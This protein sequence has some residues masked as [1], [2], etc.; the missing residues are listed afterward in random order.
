MLIVLDTNV[1]M[2]GIFF[3]GKPGKILDHWHAGDINLAVSEEIAEE[4]LATAE[5]LSQRYPGTGTD[6]IL[7]LV[8][9]QSFWVVP[10]PLEV[11]LCDDPDDDK[12]IACAL[13]ADAECVI[14]GDKALLRCDGQ[15]GVRIIKPAVFVAEF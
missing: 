14:T 7:K 5:V 1:L 9:R 12:F 2:S 13:A 6:D 4:Y 15:L 11:P 8:V 10:E 3:G